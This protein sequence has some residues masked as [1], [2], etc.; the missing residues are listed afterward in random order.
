MRYRS[1]T[2]VAL[3]LYPAA[4]FGR[5]DEKSISMLSLIR[6][7]SGIGSAFIQ[8]ALLSLALEFFGIITP[9]FMQWVCGQVLVS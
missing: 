8:V 9:F 3:E 6:N 1:F 4:T 5:K 2:G 7:V